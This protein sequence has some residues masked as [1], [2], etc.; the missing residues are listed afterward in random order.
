MGMSIFR[1]GQI[2]K[3]GGGLTREKT[4]NQTYFVYFL[5]IIES[6]PHKLYYLEI[7]GHIIKDN[8]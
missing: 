4:H 6:N 5:S 7:I 8:R 2:F 1:G 3:G